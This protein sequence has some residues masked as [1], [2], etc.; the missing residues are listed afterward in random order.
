MKNTIFRRSD[1]FR[2]RKLPEYSA[3]EEKANMITHIIGGIFAFATLLLCTGC[4]AWNK[5]AAGVLSGIIY[6]ISMI[7]VYV[8][9]SIYH[10]LD[11]DA[12]GTKKKLL[13][14]IDHCDIYGLIVGT[15][16][17]V[18]LTEMRHTHPVL[19]AVSFAVVCATAL[20]GMIFTAVDFRKYRFISYG[21]YF[22]SG[23]GVLITAKAM[24]ETYS[25]QFLR[26]LIAGGIVYTLGMIFFI[27][28]NKGKKYAHTVFH[29][30]ILAGS[31]IQ[32]IPIFKYCILP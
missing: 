23:W 17:P 26:L 21:A 9:S 22:V 4:G 31:V 5:N 24:K 1:A 19:S 15:F 10:G 7:T 6:G 12:S 2:E 14:T 29:I 20:T 16:A 25:P 11:P 27:L 3:G 13:Q 18:A 28:Q 8:I 30:F 32:F